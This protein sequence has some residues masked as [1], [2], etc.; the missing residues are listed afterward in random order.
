M[1]SSTSFEANP[2]FVDTWGWLAL[3][4]SREAQQK[5]LRTLRADCV[6]QRVVWVT[7][8][9]VLDETLTR[10]FA[11]LPFA[12]ARLFSDGIFEAQRRGLVHIEKIDAERFRQAYALRIR[13][14]DKP[15]I[16]FTDLTSFVVIQELGIRVAVTQ[17]SHFEK[18]Q[19]G[20]EL[21]PAPS[22]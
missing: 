19:L 10:L 5:N 7:T 16:S 3:A 13:Y 1:K 11:R 21:V 8:D 14:A 9:Y 15:R 4:D 18:V 12:Q 22:I 6:R 20:F 17:D 2:W